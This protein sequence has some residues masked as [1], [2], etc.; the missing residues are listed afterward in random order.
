MYCLE[1]E[2][3][4]RSEINTQKSTLA[5]VMDLRKWEKNGPP[6]GGHERLPSDPGPAR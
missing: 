2:S 4:L 3:R 6:G 1:A 5:S